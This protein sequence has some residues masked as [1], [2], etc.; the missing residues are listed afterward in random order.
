MPILNYT[1]KVDAITT[2]G[3]I[4]IILRKHGARKI[5][6]EF[7]QDGT[8]DGRVEALSFTIM[9][10]D[11]E[12]GFKLPA[13]VSAVY[14]VLQKQKVKCDWEQAERV[15]WRIIKDWV[16]AQMAIL[17]AEMVTLEEIFFPYLLDAAGEKTLFQAYRD[18]QLLL[19]GAKV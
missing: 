5:L 12:K 15:A 19:G 13:N 14:T 11:G 1:T 8:D 9:T 4:K 2:M 6:E 7:A 17:E 3:E 18:K 10:P 16:A